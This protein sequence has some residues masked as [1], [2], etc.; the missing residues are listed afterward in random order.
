MDFVKNNIFIHNTEDKDDTY[1]IV[2][3]VTH[4]QGNTFIGQLID[5]DIEDMLDWIGQYFV[6]NMAHFDVVINEKQI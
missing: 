3:G 2:K 6:Y 4:N 1:F 5:T